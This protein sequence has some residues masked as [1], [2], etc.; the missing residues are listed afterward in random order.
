MSLP[1]ND[2][3]ISIPDGSYIVQEEHVKVSIFRNCLVL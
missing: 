1:D 3:W 2:P